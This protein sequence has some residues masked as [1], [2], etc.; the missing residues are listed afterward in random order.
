[1]DPDCFRFESGLHICFDTTF[2]AFC[3]SPN[4]YYYSAHSRL[5]SHDFLL[6][7][8]HYPLKSPSLIQLRNDHIWGAPTRDT[9]HDPRAG[10]PKLAPHPWSLTIAATVMAGRAYRRAI[11][12]IATTSRSTLSDVHYMISSEEQRERSFVK[13]LDSRNACPNATPEAECWACLY[14]C[15]LNLLYMGKNALERVID[16]QAVILRAHQSQGQQRR[17]SGP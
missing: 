10:A 16:R 13:N 8:H 3:F 11:L 7:D 6:V 12:C 15:R 9:L 4:N 17:F 14:H 1:V 2:L 5:R